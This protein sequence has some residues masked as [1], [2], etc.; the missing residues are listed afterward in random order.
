MLNSNRIHERRVWLPR[1]IDRRTL[2]LAGSALPLSRLS[3]ETMGTTWSATLVLP[4]TVQLGRVE[5]AIREAFERVIQQMSPW[6]A[7]SELNRF[8]H[9]EAGTWHRLSSEFMEVMERSLTVARETGG[10][11]NPAV[12]RA[13][14]LLGFGPTKDG[15]SEPDARALC[16]AIGSATWSR[17][18]WNRE[19]SRALQPGGVQLDLGSIA[20]GF[21]VDLAARRTLAEG[22]E[23]FLLEVGGEVCARGCKPDGQPWWCRLDGRATMLEYSASEPV[24]A[25]CDSSLAASGNSVRRRRFQNRWYGHIL[26]GTC[27]PLDCGKLE[28]VFVL[29]KDC[30]TADA[31]ATA[32]FALGWEQGF[33]FATDRGLTALFIGRDGDLLVERATPAWDACMEEE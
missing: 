6:L 1:Q 23:G 19:S 33:G 4:S 27:G 16:E 14:D 13:V 9:A 18:E 24:L 28:T 8:N 7:N 12:G 32:L 29:H 17:I 26:D 22:V 30:V 3:G 5:A 2:K 25:L 15:G 10:V 21:A 31:Y 11:Y 20:K